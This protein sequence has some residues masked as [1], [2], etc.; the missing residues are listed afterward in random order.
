MRWLLK[1]KRGMRAVL[2]N[3]EGKLFGKVSVVDFLIALCIVAAIA[4]IGIKFVLPDVANVGSGE[5]KNCEYT[6]TV[7]GVR[8]ESVDAIEKSMDQMWFDAQNAQVGKIKEIISVEPFK[9][10]IHNEDGTVVN[11]EIPDKYE[12]KLR[13]QGKAVDGKNSVLLSGK[14]EIMHGSHVLLSSKEISLDVL[15]TDIEITE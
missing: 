8:Q 2:I 6:V 14:R 7:K 12:V 11:A 1:W 5:M 4:V 13:M 10:Y 15:V 3:N 9:G